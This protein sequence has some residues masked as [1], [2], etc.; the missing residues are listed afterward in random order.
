M[1]RPNSQFELATRFIALA[2]I[3]NEEKKKFMYA[4][5]LTPVDKMR[6]TELIEKTTHEIP[7]PYDK[8]QL[9]IQ[10]KF[11]ESNAQDNQYFYDFNQQNDHSNRKRGKFGAGGQRQKQARFQNIDQGKVYLFICFFFT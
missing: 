10:N 3:K 9:P 11:G 8:I 6:L 2:S 5:T 7:C 1:A 4:L